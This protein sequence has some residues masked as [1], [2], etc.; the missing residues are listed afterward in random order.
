MEQ[1]FIAQTALD[2]MVSTDTTQLLKAAVPYLPP[3]AQQIFSVYAKASEFTNTLSAFSRR[4]SR[5]SMQAASV[6]SADPLDA[7]QDMRRF[8]YG[9]SRNML[10]NMVNM[11]AVIQMLQLVS[12]PG[13]KEV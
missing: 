10:D 8:C 12:D 4:S 2:Q 7:I 1:E 13:E 3:L 6:S 9:K 11:F 5:G